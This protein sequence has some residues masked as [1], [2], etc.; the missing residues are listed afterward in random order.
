MPIKNRGSGVQ[1]F[2]LTVQGS[3]LPDP[4]SA[5]GACRRRRDRKRD[6]QFDLPERS[7]DGRLKDWRRIHIRYDRCAHT[8]MSA[9]VLAAVVIFRM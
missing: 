3:L 4:G 6:E 1:I 7:G 8:F 5:S 2:P 9:I